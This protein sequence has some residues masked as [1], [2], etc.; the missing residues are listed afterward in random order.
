M[1]GGTGP[2]VNS[3]VGLC[4]ARDY[5]GAGTQRHCGYSGS[6][7]ASRSFHALF[8]SKAGQPQ[9]LGEYSCLL[10][11]P[12]SSCYP[13]RWTQPAVLSSSL[14]RA[15]PGCGGKGLSFVLLLDT[16]PGHQRLKVVLIPH[17]RPLRKALSV[18]G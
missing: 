16:H 15:T 3:G 10:S 12:E 8:L 6:K 18:S 14:Q 13:G 11:V 2:V 9:C 7:D 17:L 4:V 5:G 1:G